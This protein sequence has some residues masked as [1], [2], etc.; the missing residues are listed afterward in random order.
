MHVCGRGGSEENLLV[1]RQRSVEEGTRKYIVG[2]KRC[3][4]VC[5]CVCVWEREDSEWCVSW[6]VRGKGEDETNDETFRC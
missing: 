4:C 5:V 1:R 3:V 2:V 6:R